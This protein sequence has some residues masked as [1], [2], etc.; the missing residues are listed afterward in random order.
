MDVNKII[1]ETIDK[2]ELDIKEK[3]EQVSLIQSLDLININEE[4]WHKVCETPLNLE[5][6]EIF[7]ILLKNIFPNAENIKVDCS[8]V[9][10]NLYGFECKLPTFRS[11]TISI[12][13]TWYKKDEGLPK[14]EN[15]YSRLNYIMKQYFDALDNNKSWKV[16]FDYRFPDLKNLKTWHKFLLWFF[17]YKWKDVHREIWEQNFKKD[18]DIY[19]KYI[20]SYDIKRKEMHEK[21]LLMKDKLIPELNKF[22]N[23]IS[24][25][26]Y[27]SYSIEEIIK[28]EKLYG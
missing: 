22:T 4:M 21:V 8:Y 28:M 18:E 3:Q 11:N 27:C 20:N 15:M 25:S 9:Y 10:F 5:G 26:E 16:L 23:N 24:K 2:L 19:K 14:K 12:N 6:K 13:T 1:K 7:L 17:Y